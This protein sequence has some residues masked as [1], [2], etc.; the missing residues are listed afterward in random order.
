MIDQGWDPTVGIF[1]GFIVVGSGKIGALSDPV[2]F[3]TPDEHSSTVCKQST[4]LVL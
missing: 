4:P 2:P 3:D 1:S